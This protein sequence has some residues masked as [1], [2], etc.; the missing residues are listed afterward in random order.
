MPLRR[1][2]WIINKSPVRVLGDSSGPHSTAIIVGK[3]TILA[4]AHSLEIVRLKKGENMYKYTEDYWIQPDFT[5]NK[6][7]EITDEGRVNIKL[8]KFHEENDWALFIRGDKFLFEDSEIAT[9]DSSPIDKCDRV[10]AHMDAIVLHCPVAL[11]F[12][13]QKV[14]EF[15]IGCQIS[16]THIAGH[17]THHVKYAKGDLIAG[18]SGGAVYVY[19]SISVLGLHTEAITDGAYEEEEEDKEFVPTHKRVESEDDAY[20]P[21]ETS[22]QE[23]QTRKRIKNE[24]ESVFSRSGGNNGNGSGLIICKFPRLMHYIKE[25]EKQYNSCVHRSSTDGE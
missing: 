6:K 16:A 18:S 19:P 10:L 21:F 14:E 24:S 13:I 4:C 12:G 17:S 7:G 3:N 9:I 5:K 22:T 25:N 15:R 2:D 8:F 20:A 1:A 23:E 11:Q